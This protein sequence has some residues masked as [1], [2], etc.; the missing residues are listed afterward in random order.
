[1]GSKLTTRTIDTG[2][3]GVYEDGVRIGTVEK[4]GAGEWWA[5]P[6][7]SPCLLATTR[8]QALVMMGNGAAERSARESLIR[9]HQQAAA[10]QETGRVS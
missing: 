7:G 9:K 2:V 10:G 5:C 4:A 8:Q 1:M 6:D 3:Y